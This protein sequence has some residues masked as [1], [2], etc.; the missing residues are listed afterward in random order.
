MFV[1]MKKDIIIIVKIIEKNLKLFPKLSH[2]RGHHTV[3]IG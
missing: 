1:K 2:E 3:E